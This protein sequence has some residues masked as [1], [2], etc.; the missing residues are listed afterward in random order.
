M[1]A[2]DEGDDDRRKAVAGRDHRHELPDRPGD[3]ADAGQA[4]AGAADE[5][6]DPHRARRRDAGVDR[7]GRCEAGDAHPV[8]GQA[9]AYEDPAGT[10]HGEGDQE[11]DVEAR[12]GNEVGQEFALGEEL[13]LREIEPSGSRQA[14][15]TSSDSTS[16]AT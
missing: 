1:Q 5:H 2:A 6:R 15:W 9:L 16:E 14:P 13:R 8:A 11:A 4:G 3:L 12:V 10:D 7:G